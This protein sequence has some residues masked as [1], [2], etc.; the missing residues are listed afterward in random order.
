MPEI[1][2]RDLRRL[3]SLESR[4]GKAQDERKA[5]MAERRELRSAVTANARR[6]REIEKQAAATDEQLKAMLSENASLAQ[7]LD[8]ATRDLEEVRA[9]SL[10]L[11][12]Q[13]D[14]AQGELKRVQADLATA[15]RELTAAN[16]E[17][18][19]LSSRLSTA[20]EQLAGKSIEPL[21]PAGDVARLVDELVIAVGDRLP[22]LAIRDGEMRLK[23]AFGR[24]GKASGFVVPTAT[25]SPDVRENLHEV[26]FRFDRLPEKD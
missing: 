14:A 17:R 16:K 2:A 19:A 8:D 18:E 9:A 4:L 10:R 5:L 13:T 11:R 1:S 24:T 20:D 3:E 6:A 23:V 7:R 25:S 26:A 22:G 12:E 15:Q 21:L